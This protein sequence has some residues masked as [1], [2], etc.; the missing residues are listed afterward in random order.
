MKICE[1]RNDEDIRAFNPI[2]D[3]NWLASGLLSD[4]LEILAE[5]AKDPLLKEE[6]KRAAHWQW[7]KEEFNPEID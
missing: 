4:I 1:I 5:K 3:L 7:K 6:L 2:P